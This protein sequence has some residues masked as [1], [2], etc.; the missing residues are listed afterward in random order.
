MANYQPSYGLC[1][2][3]KIIPD[4]EILNST[5]ALGFNRNKIIES[6]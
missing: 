5:V 1:K 3:Q 2:D 4:Q 6:L